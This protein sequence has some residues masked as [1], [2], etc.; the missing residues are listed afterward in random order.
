MYRIRIRFRNYS[1]R[2][3]QPRTCYVCFHSACSARVFLTTLYASISLALSEGFS[4]PGL[5]VVDY[6]RSDC[7]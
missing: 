4:T 1:F 7:S 6:T 5:S 2:L 3:S